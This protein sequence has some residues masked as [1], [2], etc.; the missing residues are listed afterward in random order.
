M[1]IQKVHTADLHAMY[2]LVFSMEIN[3]IPY[4]TY[5][6]NVEMI[7]ADIEVTPSF[8]RNP[9]FPL[10]LHTI[11]SRTIAMRKNGIT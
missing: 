5:N 10:I 4:S 3:P 1:N 6:G 8:I 7:P 2:A 9:R 11:I